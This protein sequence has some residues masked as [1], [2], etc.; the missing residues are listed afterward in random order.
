MNDKSTLG[1]VSACV[2]LAAFAMPAQADL[3]TFT[4]VGSI[5]KPPGEVYGRGITFLGSRMFFSGSDSSNIYE[6]DPVTG[7]ILSTINPGVGFITGLAANPDDGLL[8]AGSCCGSTIEKVDPLTGSVIGSLTV[9]AE[10][11]QGLSIS[12]GKLY[13]SNN[14]NFTI[15]E[16]DLIT[17]NTLRS[18]YVGDIQTNW[19]FVSGGNIQGIEVFGNTIFLNVDNASFLLELHEFSLNDFSHLGVGYYGQ[20]AAGSGYDGEFLWLDIE[21]QTTNGLIKLAVNPVPIPVVIDIKP[22]KK[23]E[24]VISL[25]KDKNL[26]VAIVGEESFD[27]LQVDPA[28]VKFG[29][30]EASPVRFKGQDYNRDGFPDLILTFKLNETGII[31]GDTEATLTGETYGKEVIE[32]SDSFTVEPCP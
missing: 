10:N 24:D 7:A 20:R 18:L 17:G 3:L 4:E 12:G 26:K 27:A 30:N 6:L 14:N 29:S 2:L 8:Y 23:P 13:A 9:G 22:R 15:Y 11:M 32:G 25:K 5:D 31:C 28:T 16:I 19:G 1:V 21:E